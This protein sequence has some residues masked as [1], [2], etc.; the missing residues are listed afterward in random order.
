VREYYDR[1]A[2]EYDDWYRG[3]GAF[4]ARDRPGWH[5]ELRRLIAALRALPPARTLDVACGTGYLSR[6]LRGTVCGLDQ[7]AEMLAIAAARLDGTRQADALARLPFDD[8]A[9]DRVAAGHFYGHLRPPERAGFLAEAARVA[10]ELLIVDSARRHDVPAERI[11]PRTLSDGSRHAVF[12]RWLTP[13][14]LLDELGGGW[15]VHAGRWFVAV[16]R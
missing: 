16:M 14:Q 11:D 7:S 9:F 10:P 5:A 13:E 2:P 4:A 3:D 1:R 15:V 6:H 8:G 12:K